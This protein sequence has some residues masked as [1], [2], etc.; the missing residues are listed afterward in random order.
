MNL[1]Q[2]RFDDT[3][4]KVY[5]RQYPSKLNDVSFEGVQC[6]RDGTVHFRSAITA[7]VGGNGVGKST[8]LAAIADVLGGTNAEDTIRPLRLKG[9]RVKG[10]IEHDGQSQSVAVSDGPHGLREV[11]GR[12]GGECVWLDPSWQAARYI[13][14]IEADRNFSDLLES[15]AP[16]QLSADELELAAYLVG[17]NYD[18]VTIYEIVDYAGFERLPYFRVCS[19]GA[20]YGSE[21]MG[22]GE[23]SL[24]LT[25]WTLR[26]L[27]PGSILVLEEPET[28]VSPK[29]QDCLMN[30]VA[31]FCVEKGIWAIVATHSPA[32][33]R[34]IPRGD[35]RLLVRDTGPTETQEAVSKADIAMLLGG[36]VKLGGAFLVEDQGAKDFLIAILEDQAPELLKQYAVLPAASESAIQAVLKAMPAAGD[37]LALVGVF[38]GDMRPRLRAEGWNWPHVFLPGTVAPEDQL[39]AHLRSTDNAASELGIELHR[40]EAQIKLGLNHVAGIDPHDFF[41]E[42]AKALAIHVSAARTASVRSWLKKRENSVAAQ[43]LVKELCAAINAPGGAPPLV[44]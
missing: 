16:Q 26:D 22:R 25:Y 38:D 20:K 44:F 37:W 36:G 34:R 41:T 13:G 14:Q 3:W 21:T 15:V 10:A 29:S 4:Q 1:R 24:L 11:E 23:L 39:V 28:H 2:A 12:F 18:E 6:L 35:L 40:S 43:A 19:A 33:I 32:I 8:L 9:S 27:N 31:K 7:I 42:L 5:A 17:K 30:T